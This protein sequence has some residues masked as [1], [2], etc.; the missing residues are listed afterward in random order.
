[1]N[2]VETKN[3]EKVFRD[4]DLEVCAVNDVSLTIQEGELVVQPMLKYSRRT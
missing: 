2:V 1:M 3:I 4:A